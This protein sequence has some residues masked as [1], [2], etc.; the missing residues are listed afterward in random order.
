VAARVGNNIQQGRAGV[1][2]SWP[3]P[4]HGVRF[5]VP[6]SLVA[7]MRENPLTQE[8]YPVAAGHYPRAAGHH[9]RRNQHNNYL[10]MYCSEGGGE[11]HAPQGCFPVCAGDLIYLP[12]GTNHEYS[13]DAEDPWTLYWVHFDGIENSETLRQMPD[14]QAVTAIGIHPRIVADFERLFELRWSGDHLDAFIYGSYL[15]RQIVS[16]ISLMARRHPPGKGMAIDLDA[17]IQFMQD[18]LHE[19]L[20]L[21]QLA[22][23]TGLSKFHFSRK[24]TAATGQPPIQYFI[25][26]KVQRGCQLLDASDRSIKRVAGDLGYEDVYYFSR[27]FK[28]VMGLSPTQ[29]RKNK[30]R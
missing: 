10:L 30:H 17:A 5:L 16:Y 26:L 19:H 6:A 8:M 24:F 20:T 11:V 28:K 18:H 12:A 14:W 2:S 9:M 22:E 23:K 1:T 27:L 7:R 4:K 25:H 15:L 3:L 13:A 21:E 29:Y